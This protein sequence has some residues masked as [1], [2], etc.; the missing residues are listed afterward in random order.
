MTEIW[1]PRGAPIGYAARTGTKRNLDAL[2]MAGWRLL[3]SP[4]SG[5]RRT[6]GMGY[7]LD[8]GAWSY[9]MRGTEFGAEAFDSYC[10]ELGPGAD[11][12]V[13]P[14]CPFDGPE[15][16]RMSLSWLDRLREKWPRLLL[17]VQDGMLPSDV[18]DLLGDQIGL[19]VAG[20]TEWKEET[21]CVWAALARTRS[22]HCHVARVNTRSRLR[23]V[24]LARAHSFDGSAVSRHACK[25]GR[26]DKERRAVCLP[27]GDDA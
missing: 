4:A 16:L 7:G 18:A 3:I 8:N 5:S 15:S 22:C 9:S 10:C 24:N 13:V 17:P 26:L 19:F 2:R 23:L 11:W 25:V 27:F 14:D 20:S 1:K 6:E 21:M 12:I